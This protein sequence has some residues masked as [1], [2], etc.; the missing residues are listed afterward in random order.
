MKQLLSDVGFEK[1]F[2][3]LI[4]YTNPERAAS[5]HLDY[6]GLA[7]GNPDWMMSQWWNPIDWDFINA[8]FKVE[9]GNY[10]YTNISR[11]VLVNPKERLITL[12]LDSGKEYMH[13]FNG[14]RK[15]GE[16]WSHVLLEQD[17]K[18]PQKIHELKEVLVSCDFRLDFDENLDKNQP[19]PCSQISWY[20]TVTD[21]KNGDT[22][23]ESKMPDEPNEFFWFGLPIYDSRFDNLDG[24]KIIDSGFTGATN[25]LIYTISSKNYLKEPVKPGKDYH[26]EIDILPFI[27]EAYKYGKDNGALKNSKFE[28]LILNYMNLGWEMPGSF[29][30]SITFKNLSILVK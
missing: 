9:N 18:E 10:I 24:C 28:D 12:E 1:G 13:R 7:K 2:K 19:V 11:K 27:L 26:L 22:H 23:Y 17:F 6:K 3:L 14:N 21:P 16:S 4:P 8:D 29:H 30:S 20:F 5:G 25:K 15:D